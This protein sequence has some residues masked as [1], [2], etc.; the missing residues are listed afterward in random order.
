MRYIGYVAQYSTLYHVKDICI[1]EMIARVLKRLLNSE[2]SN[3]I[4]ETRPENLSVEE[5]STFSRHQPIKKGS[6]GILKTNASAS[7]LK[8]GVHF[9]NMERS[10]GFADENDANNSHDRVHLDHLDV[11]GAYGAQFIDHDKCEEWYMD[12]LNLVFGNTKETHDFFKDCVY[13]IVEDYY[14]YPLERL[15]DHKI[16][17]NALYYALTYH[18]GIRVQNEDELF[19]RLGSWEKPFRNENSII[20]YI[21]YKVYSMRSLR[22]NDFANK[23]KEYRV[24]G[25]NE[26]A[27]NACRSKIHYIDLLEGTH[28]IDAQGEIAE[29]LLEEGLYEEAIDEARKGLDIIGTNDCSA[30]KFYCVLMRAYQHLNDLSNS[31]IYFNEAIRCLEHNWGPEHPLHTTIYR[32]MAFLMIECNKFKEAEILYKASLSCC[33]K[34]LGPNHIQTA[35][36]YMDFGRLYL[37]MSYKNESLTNFQAA[38]YIY[39][40]YFGKN[41]IPVANAAFQ[42]S[43]IME[44]NGRL[45]QGLEYAVIAYDGYSKLNGQ[46]SDYAILSLWIV[47]TISYSLKNSKTA[48]YWNLMYETLIEREEYDTDAVLEGRN[49]MGKHINKYCI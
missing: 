39:L 14:S 43:K 16:T 20:P 34:V 31:Q 46:I 3:S 41:S 15:L 36:V 2:I 28:D 10:V 8:T 47:I 13:P 45:E 38:Y 35:E 30:I 5:N 33:S 26:T 27:L 18:A 48:E 25:Q 22:I 17:H 32:I 49:D 9:R 4:K 23:Y 44:E 6:H 24:H 19:E 37:R 11:D 7:N 1:N 21:R 29:L 12:F 42:I 40:S